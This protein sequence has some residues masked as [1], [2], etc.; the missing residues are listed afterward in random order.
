MSWSL[1]INNLTSV[2]VLV[3]V[4]GFIAARLKS[5]VRIPEA[6]YQLISI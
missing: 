4:F 5:D 6:A 3:F 1:A 2:A